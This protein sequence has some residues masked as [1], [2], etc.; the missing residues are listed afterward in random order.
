MA[1]SDL[2]ELHERIVD[3]AHGYA[4]VAETAESPKYAE[5]FR[6]LSADRRKFAEHVRALLV[7]R[8]KIVGDEGSILGAMHRLFV[9]LKDLATNDDAKLV[10]SVLFG[11]RALLKAYEAALAEADDEVRGALEPQR[12]SVEA[13]LQW[14]VSDRALVAND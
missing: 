7:A 9:N 10:D 13:H 2:V 5:T 4:E 11:E 12:R 1:V 6:A 8:G 3:S 14:L